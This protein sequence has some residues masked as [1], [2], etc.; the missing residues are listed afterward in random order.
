M[1]AGR[2]GCA[3]K[4]IHQDRQVEARWWEGT[5][6]QFCLNSLS[7]APCLWGLA[8]LWCCPW[9]GPLHPGSL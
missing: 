3:R 6:L 5:R 9:A 1:G 4:K 7:A 2:A 8:C